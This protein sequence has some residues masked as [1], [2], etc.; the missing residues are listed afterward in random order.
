MQVPLYDDRLLLIVWTVLGRSP[1]QILGQL[2]HRI[3]LE[4]RKARLRRS[5]NVEF[6]S[7]FQAKTSSPK[8]CAE[9][10][11]AGVESEMVCHFQRLIM[12]IPREKLKGYLLIR[13]KPVK[14]AQNLDLHFFLRS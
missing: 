2:K 5:E 13:V 7:Y 10:K 8:S 1:T 11:T 9:F 12:D 4:L 3:Q 6:N 14:I